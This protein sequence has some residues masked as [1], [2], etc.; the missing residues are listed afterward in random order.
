MKQL[1]KLQPSLSSDL[2]RAAKDY[3][4][5]IYDGEYSGHIKGYQETFKAGA[6]W[7]ARQDRTKERNNNKKTL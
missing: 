2:D 1:E 4:E 6:E 5:R 3:Q 7:M